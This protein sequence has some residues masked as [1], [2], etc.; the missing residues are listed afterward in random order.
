MIIVSI[1][2]EYLIVDRGGAASV[3]ELGY[4]IKLSVSI[5]VS[6]W[7]VL[8]CLV[9]WDAVVDILGVLLVLV[10]NDGRHEAFPIR[11][12]EYKYGALE[13]CAI[14]SLHLPHSFP[15]KLLVST[16]NLAPFIVG[17]QPSFITVPHFSGSW[18]DLMEVGWDNRSYLERIFVMMV[19]I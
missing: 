2:E 1:E 17:V 8:D 11:S 15:L 3:G 6:I 9:Q 14:S 13:W 5:H 4:G 10:N 12:C 19:F 16:H 18:L 7:C